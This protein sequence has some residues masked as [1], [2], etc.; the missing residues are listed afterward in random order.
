MASK[1]TILIVDDEKV[2]RDTL[3]ALLS[4]QGYD[5]AFARNGPETLAMAAKIKPDV[6][7]LDVMMPGMTGYDVCRSLRSDPVLADVPVIM[8]TAL[9]DQESY[10]QGIEAGADDFVSKPFNREKL[11]ARIRT[12]TQ[13]NRYRRLLAERAKFEWVVEQATDG[14]VIL[15]EDD[16]IL[17]ANLRARLYL[18]K[19][20]EDKKGTGTETFLSLIRKQ[21]QCEPADA[22]AI[23]PAVPPDGAPL[24]LVRPASETA[25]AFWLQVDLKRMDGDYSDSYLLR[26]RDVTATIA[27]QKQMWTF[28]NQVSHKLRTPL[29]FLLNSIALLN[30]SADDL[31]PENAHTFLSLARKGAVRLKDEIQSIFEYIEALS[32]MRPGRDSLLVRS[33]PEIIEQIGEALALGSV[34]VSVA[35]HEFSEEARIK[36]SSHATE[37]IFWE[38]LENAKK[39]HPQESP[40]IEISLGSVFGRARIQVHDDGLT[41][42][43]EQLINIWTPYYQAE[44]YFTGQMTGAGLGLSL[45]ASLIWS[46]GGTCRAY[47]RSNKSGIVI[48]L[49]IPIA[50]EDNPHPPAPKLREGESR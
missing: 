27:A 4:S 20:L 39:F 17:Y 29:N 25:G 38:I 15:N 40:M 13:L 42:S 46:A 50:P 33:I 18:G 8:I 41:L 14:Y 2:G 37:L 30:E 1:K 36:L 10:L 34:S 9:D 31:S 7:L 21:Y 45:V 3:E 23:W 6:I 32:I 16:D 49:Y 43:P 24:Y 22:W 44:K 26:L 11:R 35:E 5:L 48:E 19:P 28:H 12:I 47:N